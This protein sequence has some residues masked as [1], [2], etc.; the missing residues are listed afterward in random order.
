[1]NRNLILLSIG[2]LAMAGATAA[3]YRITCSQYSAS[4]SPH[5]NR[6]NMKNQIIGKL[7][8]AELLL[9]S[10]T[11]SSAQTVSLKPKETAKQCDTSMTWWREARFGL[12]VHWGIYTVT[13]W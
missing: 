12:F 11:L 8:V 4:K 7:T 5:E 9:F 3:A 6:H 13:G 10:P 1:M 2:L